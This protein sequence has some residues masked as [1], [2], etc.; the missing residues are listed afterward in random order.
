MVKT[1][2]FSIGNDPSDAAADA[3]LLNAANFIAMGPIDSGNGNKT[4]MYFHDKDNT[5]N[6]ETTVTITHHEGRSLDVM[7]D[8]CEAMSSEPKDGFIVIA[9]E[10]G[11]DF[12]SPYITECD[13]SL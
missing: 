7:N 2:Y 3:V 11:G 13:F 6:A 8:I 10:A 5:Q 1:L 9:D 12:C 4:M